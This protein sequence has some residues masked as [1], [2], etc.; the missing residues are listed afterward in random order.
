MPDAIVSSKPHSKAVWWALPSPV[1]MRNLR[2]REVTD[3]DLE[4]NKL[5][6]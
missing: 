1:K 4:T 2:H 6:F 3:Q 5:W